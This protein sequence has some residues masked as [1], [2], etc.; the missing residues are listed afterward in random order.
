MTKSVYKGFLQSILRRLSLKVYTLLC[1]YFLLFVSVPLA[2]A[3][4]NMITCAYGIPN[5]DIWM[6]FTASAS[7]DIYDFNIRSG[8][9][10]NSGVYLGAVSHHFWMQGKTA[11][12][13]NGYIITATSQSN[14]VTTLSALECTARSDLA[15]SL[16]SEI[17]LIVGALTGIA[18]ILSFSSSRLI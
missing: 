6:Y 5:A 16:A 8:Y 4:V 10:N 11:H 3:D 15:V 13:G 9:A 7:R 14:A 12:D 2:S 1:L 18:F 17:S